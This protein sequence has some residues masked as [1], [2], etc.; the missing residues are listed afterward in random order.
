VKITFK[1]NYS[2]TKLLNFVI[3]PNFTVNVNVQ[4]GK[5]TVDASVSWDE[6]NGAF[7]YKVSLYKGKK[8]IKTV[9]TRETEAEFK[10][11]SDNT[12]YRLVFTAYNLLGREIISG[13]ED[14]KLPKV[15]DEPKPTLPSNAKDIVARYNKAVNALKK[16]KNVKIHKEGDIKLVCTDCSVSTLS[17]PVNQMLKSFLVPSDESIKFRNGKGKNS[18]G[19]T[20]TV[21]EFVSPVGRKATL[22]VKDIASASAKTAS[23]GST[24]LTI[25]L[26]KETTVFDGTTGTSARANMSVTDPLDFATLELPMSAKITTAKTVYPGTKLQATLSKNGKLTK[27][28]IYLPLKSNVTGKLQVNLAAEFEGSLTDTY[29]ITY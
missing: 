15:I 10:S 19:E 22:S 12:K 21:N 11:L 23:N 7:S 18:R 5:K 8:L 6:V 4:S 16:E 9:K 17:N 2:G 28:K 29:T 27:L 3:F 13:N 20:T 24:K 14:F 1:G 26:K 25:V